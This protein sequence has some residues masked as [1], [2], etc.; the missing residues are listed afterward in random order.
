MGTFISKKMQHFITVA[1]KKSIT[2]AAESLFLTNSPL[3]KS[4]QAI[5][6]SLGEKLFI[7]DKK[8]LQMTEFGQGLYRSLLPLYEEMSSLEKAISCKKP[9]F[10]LGIDSSYPDFIFSYLMSLVEKIENINITPID[11][12]C[13]SLITL[14]VESKIDAI[15]SFRDIPNNESIKPIA[16]PP[17]QLCF[18]IP[19]VYKEEKLSKTISMLPWLQN[20]NNHINST[21]NKVKDYLRLK[22]ITPKLSFCSYD[23]ATRLCL[24]TSGNYITIIPNQIKPVIT[25]QKIC[26]KSIPGIELTLDDKTYTLPVQNKFN[27]HKIEEIVYQLRVERLELSPAI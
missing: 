6:S 3:S 10:I 19:T 17:I 25:S 23:I 11:L 18:A 20:E 14:L 4:I 16:I 5:E 27:T 15:L 2:H 7:R 13:T 24:V 1:Q 22:N 21:S 8:G 9:K 12:S 26:F